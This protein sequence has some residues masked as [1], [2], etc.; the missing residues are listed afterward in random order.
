MQRIRVLLSCFLA[1]VLLMTGTLALA[2]APQAAPMPE[3][4]REV[5]FWHCFGGTIGQAVQAVVDSYNASQDKI[6]VNAIFQGSY[7][8]AL[9]KLKT[10][11]PV[12]AGPDMWQMFELGTTFLVSS[13]YAIPFQEMLDKDPYINIEDIEPALRRYYTYDGKMVCIPFNPS[14]PIMYYNKTAFREAGL[15]PEKPPTTFKEIAEVAEKL[16]VRDGRRITRYP[17][18][19]SIYGWFFENF[20]AGMGANY[21]NNENGRTGIATAIEFDK[22]G[23][24]KHILEYWKKLVDDEVVYD[25]GADNAAARAGFV[26]EQTC[27]TLESTAQLTTLTNAIDGKFELG[28]AYLPSMLDESQKAVIIGGANLWLAKQEDEQRVNDAWDFIKYAT[29]ADVSAKFSLATGYFCANTRAYDEP[30]FKA[31]LEKNPNFLTAINQLH[32]CPDNYATNG[33]SVG[34]MPE[35]RAIFQ[36][37]MS[38]VLEDAQTVDQ[39][40]EKMAID[41]NAAIENYNKTVYGM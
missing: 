36:A 28:T 39:A 17:M 22:S 27:M 4:R 33:A 19:L 15:D 21:V 24:G 3:G 10:A 25:Y 5:V 7:D 40:L 30:S 9:T 18:G 35:L 20:L 37:E 8:E 34:V 23:A 6:W 16:A 14:T 32:D 31:Y 12:K 38:L 41:S 1:L 2:E 29:R 13:G 26:A 11:V